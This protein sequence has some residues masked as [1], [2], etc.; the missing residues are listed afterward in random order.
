MKSLAKLLPALLL[1]SGCAAAPQV[2]KLVDNGDHL[3]LRDRPASQRPSSPEKPPIL[4]IALDGIG[5]DI[6]YPLLEQGKMPELA[7]LLGG[8][9]KTF[10]HA[11]FD[12]RMLSTLPSST[13]A[14]WVTTMSGKPPAEHGVTGNEYFVREERKLACPAPVSFSA[15]APTLEI[16]TEDYLDKLSA[17][18]TFYERLREK[19]PDA[20]MWVAMHEVYRGADKLLLAKKTVLAAAFESAVV[21]AAKKVTGEKDDADVYAKLDQ[22]VAEKV[23]DQLKVGPLPDVL[24]VYF[25]GADLFA[26]IAEHGPDDARRS[27]LVEVLDPVIGELT[28]ALQAH[29]ALER[30]WVVVGADHGHT[31]IL[32][33]DAH[34]LSTKDDE[35]PPTILKKAG[36]RVRPFEREVAKDDPFSAVLAY[37][38]ALAYVYLADRSGCERKDAVCDWKKP[39]RYEE[40]VLAAA[41]AFHKNNLDGSLVPQMKGVLDMILVRRPKPFADVDLPFEVYVGNGQTMAVD[42]WLAKNPHPTYVDVDARLRDLAVGPRG[43]R[44]GDVLLV[45]HNGDKEKPEERFYFAAPYHSWHGSPSRRDSEIPFIVANPGKDAKAI[46]AWVGGVLGDRPYQQKTTDV[47]LGLREGALR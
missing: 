40:D 38:G 33:D 10:P 13:M 34:A 28:R 4:Y 23:V 31:G 22:S 47:L 20:Q 44:A 32:H 21:G 8:R 15:S 3:A 25:T 37:G 43:E 27:Y 17:V 41:E 7:K 30:R 16:Y 36:F 39:P 18:P 9:G 42:A 6:L 29:G 12:R 45:A 5:R 11:H 26:H 35:D 1:L 2:A 14:A 24:T 19:D 46:G